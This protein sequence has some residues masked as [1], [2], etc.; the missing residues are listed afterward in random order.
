MQVFAH[1][2]L[3]FENNEP[4]ITCSNIKKRKIGT[5][6]YTDINNPTLSLGIDIPK[7]MPSE[8]EVYSSIISVQQVSGSKKEVRDGLRTTMR[9]IS[10][11]TG[12][13]Y[14]DRIDRKIR[15]ARKEII[16]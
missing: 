2:I 5:V 8:I 4:F 16:G 3:F 12:L 15:N 13:D 14:Y 10:R 7:D 9:K 11:E 6:K 1:Y